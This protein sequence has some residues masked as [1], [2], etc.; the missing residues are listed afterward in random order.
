MTRQLM[1]LAV[2]VMLVSPVSWGMVLHCVLE[3]GSASS[4]RARCLNNA[5][6][7]N[8]DDTRA[9]IVT[10]LDIQEHSHTLLGRAIKSSL[11][12]CPLIPVE[13]VRM[14]QE[15]F[16][17]VRLLPNFGLDI[18]MRDVTGLMH[19]LRCQDIEMEIAIT[20]VIALQPP[21]SLLRPV[22]EGPIIF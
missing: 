15:A 11:I 18:R 14:Q 9:D 16:V 10:Y 20:E 2:P 17:L 3:K 13:V 19:T 4:S 1:A 5:V 6:P 8:Q 21:V 12:S 7:T 22:M